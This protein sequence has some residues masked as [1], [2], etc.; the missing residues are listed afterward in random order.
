MTTVVDFALMAG[1]SY[2]SSR[3]EINMFPAPNL[4]LEHEDE[5]RKGPSG[6]EATFFTKG[7]ELVISYAG[8]DPADISGDILTDLSLAAGGLSS[9]LCQA[10]DYYL[11]LK[12]NPL[13]KDCAFTFTGHSLGGGLAALM[14]VYFDESAT[15]F[16]Q[17]PFRRSAI[18]QTQ[19][20]DTGGQ[21]IQHL[22]AGDLLTY[23][24]NKGYDDT[25]LAKLKTFVDA[26]DPSNSNPIAGDTLAA[27]EQK[28]S[29]INTD[30]EFLTSWPVVPTSNRIGTSQNNIPNGHEGV[31]GIDLHSQ[32]L[33]T[34]FLQSDPTAATNTDQNAKSL[35]RVTFKLPDLLKMVFDKNLFARDPNNKVKPEPNFLE[36]LVRHQAGMGTDLPA[37]DM[38][39]RF[40]ADLWKLARDGGLTMT[41]GNEN[42]ATLHKVSNALI[43]FAMQYYY[44]D[45]DNSKDSTRKLFFDAG[46]NGLRFDIK[47]VSTDIATA[48][49]QMNAGGADVDLAVKKDGKY[50][51]KGYESFAAYLQSDAF[52][53]EERGLIQFMLPKLRDWYIQA[54]AGGMNATDSQNRGAFM[55]GGSG[56]D[57]LTGGTADD[58]LVGNAGEDTLNGGEGR[59]ILLGGKNNDTLKGSDG[60][61]QLVGGADDDSL[62]G[63]GTKSFDS[64][65]KDGTSGQ[66]FVK[67]NGGKSL[68]ILKEGADN[69][70]LV[71]DWPAAGTLG[72][73]LQ[74]QAAEVPSA[75]LTGWNGEML[76]SAGKNSQKRKSAFKSFRRRTA[77]H[78]DA[79]SL[80]R[81][82]A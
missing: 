67:L 39:K 16:D 52:T 54:G 58:L 69:R 28:V 41:D 65:Y 80:Q 79:F 14:A 45:T 75:T 70:I 35:N 51:L 50:L 82:A 4:W 77:T 17:A 46:D 55:L 31:G 20:I 37:D 33:L 66:I 1:A 5:R 25:Q 9:Q 49:D 29:N 26:A 15:T 68:V 32:T 18:S 64:V 42:D 36:R 72:I 6:F 3:A 47:D 23:L 71:N 27:R 8:T 24:R 7:S 56:S 53:D 44:E 61:D 59:D 40:T 81:S 62:D 74:D 30:G 12:N 10:A 34:A 48:I 76:R 21:T 22:V 60:V 73:T 13:Y 57:T 43:A 63:G 11:S 2:I 78:D 38:V 19:T